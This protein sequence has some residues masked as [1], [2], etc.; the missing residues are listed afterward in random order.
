MEKI[1]LD[2]IKTVHFIGIKGVGMSA[3]AVIM[4]GKGFTVSGSDV[5][6][7]F[8]TDK[9]LEA[10][11]IPVAEFA[12]A[13]VDFRPDLVVLS[14]SWGSDNPEVKRARELNL[15]EIAWPKL[16]GLVMNDQRGIVVTGTHGKTTTSATLTFVLEKLGLDPSYLIGTGKIFGL[17]GNGRFGHGEFFVA[18]GDEYKSAES[19]NDSKFLQL[20]PEAA[21]ITSIEMDHPDV[22]KSLEDVKSAFKRFTKN[23]RDNGYI[24]ACGD[25]KNVREVITGVPGV[26]MEYYGLES[27]NDWQAKDLQY[28][29][30]STD[31]TVFHQGKKIGRFTTQLA[32]K[33]SVLNALGIIAVCAHFDLDLDKV[34]QA[35]DEFIGSERRLEPKGQAGSVLVFDDYAHHPTAIK[36]TLHGLRQRFPKREIWCVFQPHTFSRTKLLLNDFAESFDLADHVFITEV[37]G[38]AREDEG[39]VSSRDIVAIGEGQHPDMRYFKSPAEAEKALLSEVREGGIVITMGAGDIYHLAE[40]FVKDKANSR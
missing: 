39:D 34:K 2:K 10:A 9:N 4:K 29:E 13:N 16:L 37:W 11:G 7:E 36:T 5:S 35:L 31:F 8:I 24:A 26:Q 32:G 20:Y 25:D 18:E 28:N 40:N 27:N 23:I 33:H 22:F 12:A 17:P 14:P 19:D 21:I 1:D 38:S 15:R 30:E 6:E 3:L